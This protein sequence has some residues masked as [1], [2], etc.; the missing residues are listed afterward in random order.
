MKRP[1]KLWTKKY[2]LKEKIKELEWKKAMLEG[3]LQ[4]E[5]GEGNISDNELN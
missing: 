5:K 3:D 4:T 1:K 2:E